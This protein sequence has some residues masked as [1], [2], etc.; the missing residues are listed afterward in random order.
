MYHLTSNSVSS[1]MGASTKL[2]NKS[3]DVKPRM[4]CNDKMML[5]FIN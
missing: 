2:V 1:D 5:Y 4:I 3:V